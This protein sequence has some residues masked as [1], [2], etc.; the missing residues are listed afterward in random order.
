MRVKL[1]RLMAAAVFIT[2][3]LG[4][5]WVVRADRAVRDAERE[6]SRSRLAPEVR[7]VSPALPAGL[8]FLST[9][10]DFVD[11][12][13]FGDTVY[14][15]GSGGLWGYDL[16]GRLEAT[17]LVGRDL[18][19]SPPLAVAVGALAGE[20]AERLW[21]ATRR[22]LVVFDGSRFGEIRL[23]E[24]AG[25][26]VSLLMLPT[27]RML[28]G[29]SE[30]GVAAYDGR[31][32]DT[33]HDTLANVP[34]TSMGGTEGDLWIGTRDRGVVHW[35]GGVARVHGTDD[36]LP[37]DHVLSISVA[38]DSVFVGTALGVAEFQD[39]RYRRDVAP[40]V[41]ATTVL[42]VGDRLLVGTVDEGVVDVQLGSD[43]PR[44]F[45]PSDAGTGP[46]RKLVE[47]GGRAFAI[48]PD[49]VSEWDPA[50][51]LWLGGIAA[52]SAW[53]DRNV[54]ALSVDRSG[55]LWVG[56]FDRG[57]DIEGP[58]RGEASVHV[59]DDQVFCV[60]RIVWD[61]FRD[62]HVVATANGLVFMG[63]EGEV[64]DRL[65][66]SD[67]LIAAH[68]TDVDVVADGINVATAAGLTLLGPGG[69]E[70][71]Y[72][73]HGLVNN[74][75][76]ALGRRG[77]DLLA[78][79]LGGLSVIEDG[80]VRASFTTASSLLKQNW[81]SAIVSLDDD[82]FV[83]TY[84]GGIQRIAGGGEWFD[85]ADVPSGVVVNPNA[86]LSADG[87]VFAG[88]LERGLLVYDPASG[89]WTGFTAGL[90]SANVT[91]LAA[92]TGRLV[93]GTDNGVVTIP[94]EGF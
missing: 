25:N 55:R 57:L 21:I 31:R 70:S 39:G 32:L 36:G 84:G 59:E 82:V 50:T 20:T 7:P 58:T 91:A 92:S 6:F 80:L 90:P 77:S 56:Y 23:E 46:V 62:V 3:G 5:L 83:G 72:A 76:Y 22:G 63:M 35:A 78:G 8:E 73:F 51:G 85:F 33:F 13:R 79:T 18:P 27:G 94:L 54:S 49:A 65:G 43:R 71:I 93:V 30:G 44:P 52:R 41:I 34:V 86:M 61:P 17:Y 10:P 1:G 38:P 9:P 14:V 42:D 28:L 4:L 60:N 69:A 89:R 24:G 37:T 45:G 87:R 67:G 53:T 88:T 16:D 19:P 11:A 75:V 40:G 12:V 48:R 68:V 64:L 47:I 81:I 74:H 15:A 26:V 2:G 66:P 29:L